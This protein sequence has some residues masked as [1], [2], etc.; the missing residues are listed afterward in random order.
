MSGV[1]ETIEAPL[2]MIFLLLGR[3]I[4]LTVD[5]SMTI[6]TTAPRG[7]GHKEVKQRPKWCGEI[8]PVINGR[9]M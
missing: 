9:I 7:L 5:C 8:Q 2:G 3:S 6:M 4:V 1:E